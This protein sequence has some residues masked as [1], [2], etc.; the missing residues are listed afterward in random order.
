MRPGGPQF[1]ILAGRCRL[2][3]RQRRQRFGSL[4]IVHHGKVLVEIREEQ[5][6]QIQPAAIHLQFSLLQI[7]LLLMRQN[8]RLDHVR[9]CDLSAIFQ[10]LADIEKVLA[11]GCG[12]LGR[13]I[14]SR[15][16][17]K[18]IVG[19]HHGHDQPTSGDL[20]PCPR[21]RLGCA[22]AAVVGDPLQRNVLVNVTLAEIFVHPVGAD[23]SP[24]G[25]AVAL[26]IEKAGVVVHARQQRGAALYAIFFG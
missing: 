24:R 21:H 4:Q 18:A 23:K 9:V 3:L 6:R 17:D 12:A 11:L 16:H 8:L 10:L 20:R 19:L 1:R 14:F 13:G 22:R 26:G 25:R 5:H 15:R 7:A 2:H